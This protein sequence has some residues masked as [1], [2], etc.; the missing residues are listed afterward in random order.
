MR[1]FDASALVKK[2]VR[3]TDSAR[4]RRLL[5]SGDVALSRLSEQGRA[6]AHPRMPRLQTS[7]ATDKY[8]KPAHVLLLQRDRMMQN[9]V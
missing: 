4:V 3:E 6:M 7:S 1:F 2:Y 8:R 9:T 5:R